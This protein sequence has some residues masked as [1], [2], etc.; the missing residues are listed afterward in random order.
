M[1]YALEV[2]ME[3]SHIDYEG[4]INIPEGLEIKESEKTKKIELNF[5]THPIPNQNGVNGTKNMIEIVKK[6]SKNDLE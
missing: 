4:I 2:I 1:F 5:A 6:S 3:N